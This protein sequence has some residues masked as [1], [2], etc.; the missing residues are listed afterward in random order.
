[1]REETLRRFFQGLASPSELSADLSGSV[2]RFNPL[3]A[4]IETE[5][6]R[7]EFRVDRSNLVALCDAVLT[8]TLEPDALN[9]IG[10]ALQTSY[11]FI[12]DGDQDDVLANVIADWSCPEIN[13]PLTVESIARFKAWLLG[14]EPYPSKPF[15]PNAGKGKLIS[16]RSKTRPETP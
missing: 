6:M 16:V 7:G 3:V 4:R 13:Y 2:K 1:M 14:Q 10:F 12:W 15:Q 5:D 8:G 11:S 9:I